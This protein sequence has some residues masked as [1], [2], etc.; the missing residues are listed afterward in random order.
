MGLEAVHM[1]F[2]LVKVF[3]IY[4]PNYILKFCLVGWGKYTAI[5]LDVSVLSLCIFLILA[6]LDKLFGTKVCYYNR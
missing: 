5:A 4:I 1:Y 6:P 2:A 3:N